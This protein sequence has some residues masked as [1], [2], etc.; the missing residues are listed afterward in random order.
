MGSLWGPFE[1][2]CRKCGVCTS[3]SDVEPRLE[4]VKRSIEEGRKMQEA[5]DRLE[6][7]L[8]A[9]TPEEKEQWQKDLV[10][11][12]EERLNSDEL[13]KQFKPFRTPHN[14]LRRCDCFWN[15]RLD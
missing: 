7:K 1:V 8:A 2:F 9:M 4:D 14:C 6:A 15:R 10:K 3:N 11:G 5:A 12:I 13:K